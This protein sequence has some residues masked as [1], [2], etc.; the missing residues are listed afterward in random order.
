MFGILI[1]VIMRVFEIRILH[2]VYFSKKKLR[3]LAAVNSD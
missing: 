3:V 2:V 1:L